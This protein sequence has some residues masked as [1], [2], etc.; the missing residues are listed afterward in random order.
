MCNSL[1]D[2]RNKAINLEKFVEMSDVICM[3]D[4]YYRQTT[5]SPHSWVRPASPSTRRITEAPWPITRR[6]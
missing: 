4:C 3:I 5:T 2:C 1:I 6:H